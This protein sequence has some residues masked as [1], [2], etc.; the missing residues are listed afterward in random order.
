MMDEIN[1]R[2]MLATTQEEVATASIDASQIPSV[3]ADCHYNCG[4]AAAADYGCGAGAGCASGC[5]IYCSGSCST[6]CASGCSS[7][8]SGKSTGSCTGH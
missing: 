6:E 5:V 3:A 2:R 7:N 8:C 4:S 1:I